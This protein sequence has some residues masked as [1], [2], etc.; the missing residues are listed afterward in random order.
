MQFPLTKQ[1]SYANAIYSG[2]GRRSVRKQGSYEAAVASG[3]QAQ[4]AISLMRSTAA[5][6]AGLATAG[7]I[8]KQD[9]YDKAMSGT[10]IA[11]DEP[12][13][14][15]DANSGSSAPVASSARL[16]TVV[17]QDS[18]QRAVQLGSLYSND[19]NANEPVNPISRTSPNVTRMK[20]QP[21]YLKAV[22]ELSPE[23][24][25]G[26]LVHVTYAP[27]ARLDTVSRFMRKEDSY[28]RAIGALSLDGDE[29][30]PLPSR[31]KIM[32]KQD[33]Y[34]RAVGPGSVYSNDHF[35]T[36]A[37]QRAEIKESAPPSQSQRHSLMKQDSYTKAIA[38]C[39]LKPSQ[40]RPNYERAMLPFAHDLFEGDSFEHQRLTSKKR[41]DSY[42]EA[43]GQS[44]D[45]AYEDGNRNL[46]DCQRLEKTQ[47][48]RQDSYQKAVEASLAECGSDHFSSKARPVRRQESYEKAIPLSPSL[49]EEQIAPNG[50]G[51]K[52][53]GGRSWLHI[54]N[55]EDTYDQGIGSD[56]LAAAEE[57]DRRRIGGVGGGSGNYVSRR[58]IMSARQDS[59]QRALEEQIEWG[60]EKRAEVLREEERQKLKRRE[61]IVQEIERDLD[62]KRWMLDRQESE[63][64]KFRA[65]TQAEV[66]TEEE[67]LEKRG[68]L[69]RVDTDSSSEQG[70]PFSKF[71]PYGIDTEPS[72]PEMNGDVLPDLQSRE[73]QDA[74]VLIQSTFRGFKTRKQRQYDME[75]TPLGTHAARREFMP[76]SPQSNVDLDALLETEGALDA[77]LNIQSAFRGYKTRKSMA[78][79]V[80]EAVAARKIQQTFRR[81]HNLKATKKGKLVESGNH[82]SRRLVVCA[83][84]K[85]RILQDQELPQLYGNYSSQDIDLLDNDVTCAAV[86]IQ[87]MYR[88][89]ISR[90][91]RENKSQM[92]SNIS[93][94][95][96]LMDKEVQEA[97]IKIQA[98]FRSFKVRKNMAST[99]K[100]LIGAKKA[101]TTFKGVA[102]GDKRNE[103]ESTKIHSPSQRK[104]VSQVQSNVCDLPDLMD[105]EVQNAAIRIQAGFRSFKVRRNMAS[106]A[107]AVIVAKKA[108]STFKVATSGAQRYDADPPGKNS[109]TRR[110]FKIQKKSNNKKTTK[111]LPTTQKG[112]KSSL[113]KSEEG[114]PDLDSIDVQDATLKIQS[115]FR[116]FQTRKQ[117]EP[118]KVN[119]KSTV[120]M[121]I[122]AEAGKKKFKMDNLPDLKA[123]D[124]QVATAKI[125]SVFRGYQARKENVTIGRPSK[126]QALSVHADENALKRDDLP[127]LES[128]EVQDA[129]I[130]IQSAY[131]GFFERKKLSAEDTVKQVMAIKNAKEKFKDDLPDLKAKDV[132]DATVKIQSVFR[133]YQARK[134]NVTITRPATKPALSEHAD[135]D[136]LKRDDLPNLE[137]KE[138]QDAAIKIQSAYKGFSERKK[139]SAEDTVRQVMAVK[140][141]KEKFKDDLPDLKAK[142]VQEATVKIQSI[143]RGYQARKDNVTI[144]RPATKPALSEQA[145]NDALN[146]GDLPSLKS[147]EVQDA[148]IK[149]QSAYKGFYERKKI[150]AEDTVRQVMVVTNAK[151]KFKD[152]LPDMKAK[153]V[154]DATVKIQGVFRGYQA[155]RE[156]AIVARPVKKH[157]IIEKKEQGKLDKEELPNLESKEVQDAT[158]K[159]QSVYKG[160][161]ERK[162]I[163][164][165]HT[166][167]QAVAVKYAHKKFKDDLPDLKDKDFQDATVKIQSA[168]RGYQTRKENAPIARPVVKQAVIVHQGKN[169]DTSER[170]NL[171]KLGSM[172]V[173]DAATK[174]QSAYRGF[175]ERNKLSAGDTVRQAMAVQ[176]AKKKIK[177]DLPDLKAKD[178]Q[179]ATVKIQSVFRG[180]QARKENTNVAKP[181]EKQDGRRHQGKK[182]IMV[183]QT[184][185]AALEREDLPDIESKEVQD[186]AIKIQSVYKGFL[187]RK[188]I[189]PGDAVKQVMSVKYAKEKFKDDLPDLKSK[190]V[191][192][193]TVKIQS[194][195]R[196]Y[197]ARKQPLSRKADIQSSSSDEAGELPDL[198]ARDVKEATIKIQAAYRGF[199]TRKNE[200]QISRRKQETIRRTDY[201]SSSSEEA[202]ELPDL[203]A[204][205]VKEAAAKIQAAYRGFQTRKTVCPVIPREQAMIRQTHSQSSSSEEA[206]ELPDLNAKDVKEAA[207]KIQ[208]AY[209]GFQRRKKVSA[210][211]RSQT[212]SCDQQI[213]TEEKNPDMIRKPKSQSSPSEEA[214]ELPDLEAKDVKKAAIKIQAAYKG[215]QTRKKVSAIGRSQTIE[216]IGYA[217]QKVTYEANKPV[218]NRK[219]YSQSSSSEEAEDLPDL[220]ARDVKDAAIKI[221]E[222][223]KG[224]QSR[225][226]VST[227]D[228]VKKIAVAKSSKDIF[229]GSGRK[230]T[231]S[232]G[233]DIQSS[234]SEE[235]EELPD[236][237]ARDVK[238]AAAKIQ[239]AY[240]G[241]QIRKKRCQLIT[242][243]PAMIRKT[244]SQSSSSDKAEELPDLNAK[245]VKD[246]AVKIQL[247][248]KGFQKR[249]RVAS[250]KKFTDDATKYTRCRRTHSASSSSEE[251]EELPDL[252]KKDVKDA[253]IKIQAAYK[254][255]QARKRASIAQTTRKVATVKSAETKF[256]D[257]GRRQKIGD[258]EF[259]KSSSKEH[260]ADLPDLYSKDIQDAA[261]KIQA[262][263][264]GFQ[265][266]KTAFGEDTFKKVTDKAVAS[267]THTALP[268]TVDELDQRRLG[269]TRTHPV[270]A[271]RPLTREKLKERKSEELLRHPGDV[272]AAAITLQRFFRRLR[273][274]RQSRKALAKKSRCR[275]KAQR[276]TS[277]SSGSHADHAL[278]THSSSS[279]SSSSATE[280][281]SSESSSSNSEHNSDDD[282]AGEGKKDRSL[283]SSSSS[284]TADSDN[285][286][287]GGRSMS[288]SDSANSRSSNQNST[289]AAQMAVLDTTKRKETETQR[290]D[291]QKAASVPMS[292]MQTPKNE[293]TT[294]KG[295]SA[296]LVATSFP[297]AAEGQKTKPMPP[298]RIGALKSPS[299]NNSKLDD[300]TTPTSSQD[301]GVKI[302]LKSP[303]PA[304]STKLKEV[305]IPTVPATQIEEKA[306]AISEEAVTTKVYNGQSSMFHVLRR[307]SL[308]NMF[309]KTDNATVTAA[310]DADSSNQR[311]NREKA[312]VAIAPD[313]EDKKQ[314]ASASGGF[315]NSFLRRSE[316]K[317]KMNLKAELK[318]EEGSREAQVAPPALQAAVQRTGM[319][320]QKNKNGT[321]THTCFDDKDDLIH[322]VL[323]AVEENWLNQA[324]QPTLDKAKALRGHEHENAAAEL[325]ELSES[326]KDTHELEKLKVEQRELDDEATRGLWPKKSVATVSAPSS[327]ACNM[328]EGDYDDLPFL[329]STLPQERGGFT[330]TITPSYQRVSADCKLASM[331]RP[332]RSSCLIQHKQISTPPTPPEK[333]QSRSG[334]AEKIKVMLP[335]QDSKARIRVAIQ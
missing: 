255:F 156:N 80:M 87:S 209:K 81:Y 330:V 261:V 174:I 59:Y 41:Q 140:N 39:E 29:L 71:S 198:S 166:V 129:A 205:D 266:R 131:K 143:F 320:P 309:K 288:E 9:S 184:K 134:E 173:Q 86:K 70:V 273:I 153:D 165:S 49:T 142:D 55:I 280:L 292:S 271:A 108:K 305:A 262:A 45:Y 146:R 110:G 246:A 99:T 276:S 122:T 282:N 190:D 119:D 252:D 297:T 245:G 22:G 135:N 171:P 279:S 105:E 83:R 216:T 101:K 172:E 164:A 117:R 60:T 267:P 207:A 285:R 12:C 145:D 264:K 67:H 299:W 127:N 15:L 213:F 65:A 125:Q 192:A 141:A 187:E 170:D 95:P 56:V 7:R 10:G 16:R 18:Y 43:I 116:G 82:S 72:Q 318:K 182:Q 34:N 203:N 3:R 335:K 211:G 24:D 6:P 124:V 58:A 102:T 193:A 8:K 240:K 23:A 33:S 98:G 223:Y 36:Q 236:L 322:V 5:M 303:L 313:T 332:P 242:R 11:G 290:K 51:S 46:I 88:G 149:I 158:I 89:Y 53:D 249:K 188:N 195:F 259:P 57:A 44:S 256:V 28:Q 323:N 278:P 163:S 155:R 326:E 118:S 230:S 13:D 272:V 295:F 91:E 181:F 296:D 4:V 260:E 293:D 265:T 52:G 97:A 106:T 197:Q 231:L 219:P 76:S 40:G 269:Q 257:C 160:F 77:A 284:E 274:Q 239:A 334:P 103:P 327:A 136:A 104:M 315:F 114:L 113:K 21:S 214:D 90:R 217:K 225:K 196:G 253:A 220:E 25:D 241:F 281:E 147:K 234:S 224:F 263:Y 212:V 161:C 215:F 248:Y 298:E 154:Q 175:R 32:R 243:K 35:E 68:V 199:Q 238:E 194:V 200:S 321:M 1:D 20:K 148:A 38:E 162:K 286:R 2:S 107:Q 109:S 227:S 133:G 324:P 289:R 237:N 232:K 331:S 115:A 26:G 47:L 79:T 27:N 78:N 132:Q 139:I 235:A 307:S 294:G 304:R 208:A 287:G 314:P 159:I 291:E 306:C 317:M 120:N 311:K 19:G 75:T 48:S 268:I 137:S 93:D 62:E 169:P 126:K 301:F 144:T 69:F 100:A 177:D 221:Q 316:K 17:K 151:D 189:S 178:V 329:E 226:I 42:L 277:S 66:G 275:K 121:F 251:E 204:K 258:R 191:Q 74:A 183:L 300:K 185:K 319:E 233:S 202:E 94:L 123:K 333:Q 61:E 218:M 222:A 84:A 308:G 325:S 328:A 85:E 64:R 270:T 31:H 63:E 150:S 112:I 167:R 244:D 179:D 128:K 302:A 157:E 228:T 186:A 152:D 176:Y 54:A 111:T 14:S 283:P 180:Y 37:I 310:L 92:E 201:Q 210:V 130:K 30:T 206:D 50:G 229:S 73:V 138:V 250:K 312:V 254:G 247:A 168:F 96:D